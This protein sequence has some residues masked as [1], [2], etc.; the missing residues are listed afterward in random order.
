MA[1]CPTGKVCRRPL[2][3]NH[4]RRPLNR[5]LHSDS[6]QLR[7]ASELS[8]SGESGQ[9]SRSCELGFA[10][11]ATTS[12]STPEPTVVFDASERR[13][14][15]VAACGVSASHSTASATHLS[16]VASV[17]APTRCVHHLRYLC[18]SIHP[19]RVPSPKSGLANPALPAVQ[20]LLGHRRYER[21]SSR[22]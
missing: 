19:D 8:W 20:P 1:R 5:Q 3:K 17:G 11:N 14:K 6:N 10:V 4:V 12:G 2:R 18:S 21:R 7:S 15:K 9:R 16:A 13:N 22:R